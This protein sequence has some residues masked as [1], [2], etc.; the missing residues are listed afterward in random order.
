MAGRAPAY[1][2]QATAPARSHTAR[3]VE[4]LGLAI[5]SGRQPE[6]SLLPGAGELVERYGISRTV[7][8]EA[9]KT[10]AAKGLVQAKAGT[11]TRVHERA[12]WNFFDPDVLIWHAQTG[13]AP[14]FLAHLAEMRLA[15][16]P[17][18]AGLAARRRSAEQVVMIHQWVDKMEASGGAPHDFVQAD[19][20]FHLA[21]AEAAAN[22]F[23]VSI[24]TLI[25]VA[26]VAMLR[27]SSPAEEEARLAKSVAEHR[28]VAKA[29]EASDVERARSAMHIV[30]RHGASVLDTH[31]L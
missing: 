9:L 18:A 23:F 5:I 17:H 29:I 22:P 19:L 2:Y 8:R 25:E 3:V 15:L 6:G 4:D 20:G 7:V 24:S 31:K 28:E 13:F 12:H 16:E 1:T 30:V 27:I 26:L 21:V 11:G 10:L 14:D